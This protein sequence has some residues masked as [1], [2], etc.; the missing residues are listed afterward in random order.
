[1]KTARRI[2]IT[3]AITQATITSTL[4]TVLMG[5]FLLDEPGAFGPAGGLGNCKSEFP[6]KKDDS[7]NFLKFSGTTPERSLYDALK[8][9]KPSVRFFNNGPVKWFWE[10]S[11]ETRS[12]SPVKDDGKEPE[13]LFPEISRN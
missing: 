4:N 7:G 2:K 13:K 12:V 1:M 9:V 5:F 6:G 8:L 10:I 3:T 11:K